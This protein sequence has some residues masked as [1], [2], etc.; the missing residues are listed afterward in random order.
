MACGLV[1]LE[2]WA[3]CNL[4]PSGFRWPGIFIISG[5]RSPTVQAGLD[6]PAATSLHTYNPALAADLR[7]G[8]APAS[9]TPREVWAALGTAWK[10]LV[11]GARWGGDFVTGG[12]DYNHFDL[13]LLVLGER[14]TLR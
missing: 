3:Q 13:G 6:S 9:T 11:L 2:A 14:T 1:T 5:Y 7:V 8:D 4:S 10:A 12:P